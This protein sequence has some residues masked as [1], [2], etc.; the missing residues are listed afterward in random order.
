VIGWFI[1]LRPDFDPRVWLDELPPMDLFGSLLFRVTDQQL[2]V[3]V[4]RRIGRVTALFGGHLPSPGELLAVEPAD[5]RAFPGARSTP[6]GMSPSVS[7]MAE[8]TSNG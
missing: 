7:P 5:L 3:A 4:T 2:S 1:E 6:S 8:W